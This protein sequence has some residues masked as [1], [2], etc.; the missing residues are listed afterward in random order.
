MKKIILLFIAVIGCYYANAQ[1]GNIKVPK[2][3]KGLTSKQIVEYLASDELAGRAPGTEGDTLASKFIYNQMKK[4][5]L[6]PKVSD[7]GLKNWD[8]KTNNIYGIIKGKT[9]KYIVVGA[10]YDHLGMGGKGTGSRRIDTLA[11]HNGADDNASGVAGMLNIAKRYAK[12]KKMDVGLIFVAFGAEEKGIVG[13]KK[14]MDC[15]KDY[16]VMAMINLD[17]IGNLRNNAITVG[18]TGTAKE[19]DTIISMASKN[20]GDAFRISRSKQGHGPSDH[21]SFYAKGIPVVYIT[22]GATMDYHTPE[23]D[24]YKLNYSGLDSVAH[25]ASLIIDQFQKYPNGLTFTETAAPAGGSMMRSFKVTLGLMPDF[26]GQVEN[27]LRADIVVKGKPAHTAGIRNG[28]IITHINNVKLNNIE[29]YMKCLET[30]EKN[31]VAVVK[32]LRDNKE[33]IFNVQL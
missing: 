4:L 26:T 23:D 25:F 27:G 9:N 11:V 7:F 24:A 33:L 10:H 17:M 31:T 14:F 32:V 5:K 30:L 2:L 3:G 18:G 12:K 21:S 15:I 8:Y 29:E 13:S 6:K 22:T 16:N 20:F 1:Q 19:M 28:D